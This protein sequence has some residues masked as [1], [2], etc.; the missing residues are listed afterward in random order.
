MLF[1]G[2]ATLSKLG[3][4]LASCLILVVVVVLVLVVVQ[5]S[6]SSSSSSFSSS[7]GNRRGLLVY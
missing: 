2:E 7:V 5:T 1:Q 3:V 6:S 4:S